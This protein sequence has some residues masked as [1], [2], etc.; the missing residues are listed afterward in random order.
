MSSRYCDNI[1]AMWFEKSCSAWSPRDVR[2]T[3]FRWDSSVDTFPCSYRHTTF[4]S[5]SLL[6]ICKSL[7]RIWRA[8][9]SKIKGIEFERQEASASH[10]EKVKCLGASQ[11]AFAVDPIPSQKLRT[12]PTDEKNL[13]IR[14]AIRK[15]GFCSGLPTCRLLDPPAGR[16]MSNT[17]CANDSIATPNA[18]LVLERKASLYGS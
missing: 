6:S 7:V 17:D 12:V 18:T 13:L 2:N 14:C 4:R 10:P 9:T 1:S 15:P 8:N 5:L 11:Q 16:S 3:A